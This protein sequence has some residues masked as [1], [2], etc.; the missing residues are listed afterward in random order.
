MSLMAIHVRRALTK[1]GNGWG[2]R[3]T[4][5]EVAALGIKPGQPVE[6]ELSPKPARNRVEDLPSWDLGGRTDLDDIY[7]ED[8]VEEFRRGSR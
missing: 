3:L 4:K 2:L 6:A 1:W 5:K 7:D 8:A